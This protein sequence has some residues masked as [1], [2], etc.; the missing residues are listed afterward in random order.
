MNDFSE[1]RQRDGAGAK[2]ARD[3]HVVR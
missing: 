3:L 1:V 2:S